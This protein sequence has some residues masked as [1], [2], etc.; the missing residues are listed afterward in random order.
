MVRDLIESLRS[1]SVPSPYLLSTMIDVYEE[2]AAGGN[3]ESLDK[4]MKVYTFTLALIIIPIV[5]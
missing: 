1:Q 5:M 4:A 3:K 2:E